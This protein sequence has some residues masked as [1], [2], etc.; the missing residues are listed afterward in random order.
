LVQIIISSHEQHI[1]LLNKIRPL[2]KF[3]EIVIPYTDTPN[4]ELILSFRPFLIERKKVHEWTGT[5]SGGK[6]STLYRYS[7]FDYLFERLCGYE[8]FFT[9]FG[10]NDIAFF[11]A[12]NNVIFYTT[13]HEGYAFINEAI[14]Y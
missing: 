10:D 8:S 3:I 2:T 11:D 4:D 12:D 14:A 5:I 7:S 1:E 6:A 13:T 9:S